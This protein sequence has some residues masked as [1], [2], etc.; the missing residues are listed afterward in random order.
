MA[1]PEGVEPVRFLVLGSLSA[2]IFSVAK[3]G[4]GSSVGV[5]AVPIMIFACG[6]ET[7]LAVG[8]MLPMLIA[9]DYV[10]VVLW[11]RR[12]DGRAVGRLFAGA[13]LGIAAG[14]AAL[15]GL[16][17]AG[18][19]AHQA[20]AD[21]VLKLAVG[22]IGLGFV[23]LQIVN[24][25]RG[26]PLEVR[27]TWPAALGLGSASGLTSTFAH[28]A[29]PLVAAYLL[30]QRMAKERYVASMAI[31][32]WAINHAK[33]IP[34]AHLGLLR[35]ETLGATVRLVPAIAAGAVL[36]R[37]LNA[38]LGDRSFAGIVYGLLAVAG[39]SLVVKGVQGLMGG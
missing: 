13:C 33:L 30:S 17:Q 34:Y 6:E 31:A 16:K 12:W 28:A 3:A 27:P 15:W 7:T 11:W 9:A 22:A 39:V 20:V 5:L 19:G 38:R 10:A 29:G 18:A 21:H 35:P 1:L 36:G 24:G 23:A 14:W 2:L 26:R 37:V 32:F 4:L 8:L 25:R